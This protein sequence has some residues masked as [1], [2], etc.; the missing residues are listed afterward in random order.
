MELRA[1]APQVGGID[2]RG[3]RG[4]QHR[5]ESIRGATAK[6]GLSGM[7]RREVGGCGYARHV[8]VAGGVHGDAGA[9]VGVAATQI[10]RIDQRGAVRLELRDENIIPAGIT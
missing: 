10:S 8:G 4:I 1:A 6:A 9:V 5:H 2:Q 3:A 7:A